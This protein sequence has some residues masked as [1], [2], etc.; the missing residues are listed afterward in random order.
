MLYVGK[1]TSLHSRVRSYFGDPGEL[2]P[3]NRA[4]V[5][6]IADIDYIVVGSEIEALILE[7]EY[8][9]QYQPKIQCAAA[10]RQKLSIYQGPADRRLSARLSRAQLQT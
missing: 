8:I 3:K 4:L 5:A 9:K 7:N 2:S 10:R 1:A 6:K